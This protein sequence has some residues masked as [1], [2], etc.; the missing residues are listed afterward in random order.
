MP[1]PP[2]SIGFVSAGGAEI[3]TGQITVGQ[4]GHVHLVTH[5][6]HVAIRVLLQQELFQLSCESDLMVDVSPVN[7]YALSR[8]CAE[9]HGYAGIAEKVFAI[10]GSAAGRDLGGKYLVV[11]PNV[12]RCQI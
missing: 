12:G 6:A 10:P 9:I 8:E 1:R 11:F 3:E 7:I 2:I 5:R 4:L